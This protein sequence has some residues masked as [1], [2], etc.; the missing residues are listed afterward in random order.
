MVHHFKIGGGN[1]SNFQ[2]NKNENEELE[3]N[4]SD[5]PRKISDKCHSP[6]NVIS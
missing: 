1:I 6:L 3:N 4:S 2:L 5:A